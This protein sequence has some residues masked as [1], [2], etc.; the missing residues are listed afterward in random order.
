VTVRDVAVLDRVR[1]VLSEGPPLRLAVLFGSA[2]RGA[3]HAGSD[4]DVGILPGDPDLALGTELELQARLERACGRVVDLVR[5]DRASTLLRWEAARTGIAA[6]A[7]PPHEFARFVAAAA[8]EHADLLSALAGPAERY[9]QRLIAIEK[10]GWGF[11]SWT[12]RGEHLEFR[13]DCGG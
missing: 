3:L 5:L 1:R 7:D 13:R 10:D 4:I 12:E 2:V 11:E 9:R 8:I 6:V